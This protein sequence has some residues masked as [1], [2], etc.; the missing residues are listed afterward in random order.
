MLCDKVWGFVKRHSTVPGVV[1]IFAATWVFM[2]AVEAGQQGAAWIQAFGS[3]AAI[4]AATHIAHED[5]RAEARREHKRGQ[6]QYRA[7]LIKMESAHHVLF[8]ANVLLS[9]EFQDGYESD[10]MLLSAIEGMDE[11][12]AEMQSVSLTSLPDPEALDAVVNA[13]TALKGAKVI[14]ESDLMKIAEVYEH[15]GPFRQHV[16]SMTNCISVIRSFITVRS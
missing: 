14:A 6:V 13:I 9:E 4:L 12:V 15:G 2:L 11:S 10:D 5:R 16:E 7:L 1:I 8:A 3:I